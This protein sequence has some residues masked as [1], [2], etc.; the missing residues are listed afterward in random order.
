[1]KS[2]TNADTPDWAHLYNEGNEMKKFLIAS[3]ALTLSAGI[4][5]AD[6]TF[7]GYGRF[8]LAY[9]G[10]ATGTTEKTT[11]A[12]RYRL[13]IDS[14][15]TSDN[16]VTFGARLRIQNDIGHAARGAA[17]VTN[18]AQFYARFG[19]FRLDVG[20]VAGAGDAAGLLYGADMGFAPGSNLLG[21]SYAAYQSNP[22]G[23][24]AG[25]NPKDRVG[26]QATYSAAGF[27]G[28]L[29]YIQLDQT[30]DVV[31]AGRDDEAA[32]SVDYAFNQFAISAAYA[33][34]AGFIADN[35]EYYLGLAYNAADFTVGL[36]YADSDVLDT[37]VGVYGNYKMG[38]TTLRGY[39]ARNDAN[40][41]LTKTFY[42]IGADYALGGGV[43][44]AG[45]IERNTSKKTTADLGV[46]FNF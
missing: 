42:G 35:K 9:N 16:G 44:L 28:R 22:Y 6:V 38:A 10:A 21:V 5:A 2:Y 34:N 37:T 30:N 23:S 45:K 18:A 20:N 11:I 17:G 41:N 15:T 24:V 19:A 33:D 27:T 32:I 25:S 4:A 1:M 46:R 39:V 14:S 29:S 31:Y 26:V 3:T 12:G 8:G 7:S 36:H 43:T 40:T 13:N